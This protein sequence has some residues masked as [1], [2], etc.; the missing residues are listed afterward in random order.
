MLRNDLYEFEQMQMK[1]T[2]AKNIAILILINLNKSCY[3]W[4]RNEVYFLIEDQQY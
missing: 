2:L 3:L 4:S 1:M